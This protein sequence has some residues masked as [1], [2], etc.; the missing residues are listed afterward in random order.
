MT[1][2]AMHASLPPAAT[3]HVVQKDSL[4]A[5]ISPIVIPGLRQLALKC[6]LKHVFEEKLI[7]VDVKNIQPAILIDT[8]SDVN[9]SIFPQ[10]QFSGRPDRPTL[11]HPANVSRRAPSTLEGRSALIHTIRPIEFN[12]I[13]RAV[14]SMSSRI[15]KSPKAS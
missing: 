13:N 8:F 14:V 5:A 15:A 2:G 3:H 6:F 10:N 11:T 4:T 9:K 1:I 7:N 12:A